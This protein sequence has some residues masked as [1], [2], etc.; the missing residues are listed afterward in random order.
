M[1]H[2]S[3]LRSCQRK[4]RNTGLWLQIWSWEHGS[5]E[6]KN[7]TN[8]EL[9][10]FLPL[11]SKSIKQPGKQIQNSKIL[12]PALEPQYDHWT[13]QTNIFYCMCAFSRQK[14][15]WE[16]MRFLIP[17]MLTTRSEG[18]IGRYLA[19]RHADMHS[20]APLLQ[21]ISFVSSRARAMNKTMP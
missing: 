17:H 10:L 3:L 5:S 4:S 14:S 21:H 15:E 16:Y 12:A 19:C 13:D 7:Q 20:P 8:Q 6:K 9:K 2:H 11:L 18:K 1:L